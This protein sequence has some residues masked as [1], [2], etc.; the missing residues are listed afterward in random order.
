M[1]EIKATIKIENVIKIKIFEIFKRLIFIFIIHIT[2][3]EIDLID[4]FS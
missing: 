2:T 4:F 3:A 1:R